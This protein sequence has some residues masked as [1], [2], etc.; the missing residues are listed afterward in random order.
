MEKSGKCVF[1][2]GIHCVH[3]FFWCTLCFFLNQNFF[4]GVSRMHL[5]WGGMGKK[6]D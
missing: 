4:L 6:P 5:F 1:F 3:L 2:C